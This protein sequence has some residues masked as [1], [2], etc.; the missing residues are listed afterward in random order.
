MYGIMHILCK[1]YAHTLNNLD[2]SF[3]LE[4]IFTQLCGDEGL[5]SKL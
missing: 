4:E 5:T 1:S 3:F 2:W